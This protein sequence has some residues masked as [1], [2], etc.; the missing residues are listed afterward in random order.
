MPKLNKMTEDQIKDITEKPAKKESQ[1]QII[2]KQYLELMKGYHP[3][4]WV[5]V[6]LEEGE[7]RTSV[8]NRLLAAAKELGWTLAFRRTSGGKITF[9][10][11]KA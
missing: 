1:R 2:R 11:K 6:E 4:E 8:R 7:N 5:S 3:G 9:E 10:I